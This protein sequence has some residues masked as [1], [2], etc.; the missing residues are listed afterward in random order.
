MPSRYSAVHGPTYVRLYSLGAMNNVEIAG[1][2][3]RIPQSAKAGGPIRKIKHCWPL[4]RNSGISGRISVYE[5]E[6]V[7]L[8]IWYIL[9]ILRTRNV[10]ADLLIL[11]LV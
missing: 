11:Y 7:G 1:K 2:T 8:I 4:M 5:L 9:T 6:M 3:L 10:L